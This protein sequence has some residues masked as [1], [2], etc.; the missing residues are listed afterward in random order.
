VKNEVEGTS[1]S[2]SFPRRLVVR[3][4]T[5]PR[6]PVNIPVSAVELCPKSRVENFQ[7]SVKGS[8]YRLSP[9][10]LSPLTN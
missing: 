3:R 10:Q 9:L 5:L 7:Q 2:I 1:F 6:D 8:Q 4:Q